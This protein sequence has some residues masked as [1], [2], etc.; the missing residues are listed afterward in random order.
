MQYE[1]FSKKF[2]NKIEKN[3]DD[4]FTNKEELEYPSEKDIVDIKVLNNNTKLLDN[5]KADI[6]SIET[7][8]QGISKERSE[9]SIEDKVKELDKKFQAFEEAERKKKWLS[10]P[11]LK[12]NEFYRKNEH[13]SFTELEIINVQGSG[14]FILAIST[15]IDSITHNSKKLQFK[16]QIDEE[17]IYDV[18][19][20]DNHT[21]EYGHSSR[22]WELGIV[23]DVEYTSFTQLGNNIYKAIDACWDKGSGNNKTLFSNFIRFEVPTLT[24]PVKNKTINADEYG[25]ALKT[26]T[27]RPIHALSREPIRFNRNLKVIVAHNDAFF[28]GVKTIYSLDN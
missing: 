17:I 18:T 24:L 5:K 6:S 26:S 22:Q 28:V 12:T 23:N 2:L 15:I 25:E 1:N 20:N 7:A 14:Y 27:I 21:P 10:L 8:L 13:S 11:N 9:Y 3:I 19:I 16:I 4:K